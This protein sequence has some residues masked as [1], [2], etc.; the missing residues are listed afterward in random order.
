MTGADPIPAIREEDAEGEIAAIFAD[1]RATLGVPFVNLIWR[2]LATIPNALPWTWSLA[3]PL[4]KSAE[5]AQAADGLRSEAAVAGLDAIPDFVWDCGGVPATERARIGRLIDDYNLA[6]GLNFLAMLVASAALGSE[7]APGGAGAST[8]A[9]APQAAGMTLP[10]LL[11][12]AELSPPLLRLVREF[13][14]FGRL[15]QSEAIASL[16][17]HLGHWPS[18]LALACTALRPYHLSGGLAAAQQRVI[19]KGRAEAAGFD[20]LSAQP[21][22]AI[23]PEARARAAGSIDTFTRLM[24][25]RMVVMGGALK[26]ILGPT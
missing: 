25:G 2:H 26:T 10:R 14:Q 5:F 1:L 19:A 16:Y 3:K 20:A 12:L 21:S 17:R 11:G 9:P 23:D 8:D 6:N 24:I 4:Y 22:V 7:I 15:G 13:D 18:F